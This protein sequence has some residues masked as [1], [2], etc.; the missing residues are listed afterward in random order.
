MTKLRAVLFDIDDTLFSTSEFARTARRNSIRALIRAGVRMTEKELMRE[1]EEVIAEFSSNYQKHFDKLLQR[2]PRSR[3]RGINPSILV[4][5]A[6]IGYHDTKFHQLKP[7][8]DAV[9]LLRALRKTSLVCGVV[10][11]GLMVKQAEKLLRLG[12]YE[13]FDPQAIFISDE[14]GISKPNPKLYRR[15]CQSLGVP[16]SAVL[17]VGDNPMN[18]VDPPNSIGMHTALLRR[19]GKYSHLVGKTYAD[20]TIKSF[21]EL[22]QI[23]S[24]DFGIRFASGAARKK[25]QRQKKSASPGKTAKTRASR[26]PKRRAAAK[27]ARSK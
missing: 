26:K 17:Y 4:A 25:S 2:I 18:D 6:V 24:D 16:P 5:A 14:I 22:R 11:D 9:T 27:S 10:T 13:L 3:Y 15:A 19:Y 23:L 21:R 1:L 12:I 8:A 7:Y 20:F